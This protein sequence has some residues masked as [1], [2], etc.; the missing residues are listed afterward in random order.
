MFFVPWC[1]VRW[2]VDGS[3]YNLNTPAYSQDRITFVLYDLRWV[4]LSPVWYDSFTSMMFLV[5]VLFV[6]PGTCCAMFPTHGMHTWELSALQDYIHSLPFWHQCRSVLLSVCVLLM[7]GLLCSCDNGT[8]RD[9]CCCLCPLCRTWML[10]R[11]SMAS[12]WKLSLLG[13][14]VSTSLSFSRLPFSWWF[15]GVSLMWVNTPLYNIMW[16]VGL[17]FWFRF[18]RVCWYFIIYARFKL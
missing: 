14:T 2:I 13:K 15:S 9:F 12:T 8:L 17:I 4:F 11:G 3:C 1:H 10:W 5:T 6:L 18:N 16:C 7:H